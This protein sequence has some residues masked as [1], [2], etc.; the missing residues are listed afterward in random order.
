MM[1]FKT[2]I[3]RKYGL[4]MLLLLIASMLFAQTD[5]VL[6]RINGKEVLRSEFEHA[7]TGEGRLAGVMPKER[8]SLFIDYKLKI[9]EAEA[10][11]LD[12]TRAFRAMLEDYRRGLAKDYL[13][14]GEAAELAARKA[15]DKLNSGHRTGQVRVTHIYKHLSQNIPGYALREVEAK[16]DSIYGTLAQGKETERL[17][18]A[19]VKAYSDDKRT[20]WVSPLQM[21]VEFEDMAYGLQV[22]EVSRPFFTPQGIHIVKVVEKKKL[23]RLTK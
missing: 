21:P 3:R 14:D 20:F 23:P 5:P 1:I 12:T 8:I 19:Y 17:F 10:T 7:C 15:Y 6:M 13:T 9:V 22:G 4:T 16:M 18:D 11:G 2:T